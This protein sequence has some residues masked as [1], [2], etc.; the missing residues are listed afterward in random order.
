MLMPRNS[1]RRCAEIG[2]TLHRSHAPS[3]RPRKFRPCHLSTAPDCAAKPNRSSSR[4]RRSEMP[5]IANV[6]PSSSAFFPLSL[7]I[8]LE[9]HALSL[10]LTNGVVRRQHLDL[11]LRDRAV[12]A[13]LTI[14]GY[15]NHY[16]QVFIGDL[17]HRE[18]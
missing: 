6:P 14:R 1:A 12:S 2:C 10:L 11:S 17:P 4:P 13:R 7:S 3:R 8:G 15:D 18:I 16:L 9:S 5:L